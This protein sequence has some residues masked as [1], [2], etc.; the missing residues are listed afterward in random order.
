LAVALVATAVL[1][2]G[3][4]ASSWT[5]LI[6]LMTLDRQNAILLSPLA[7]LSWTAA[8]N[9]WVKGRF[10]RLILAIA[11]A[12]WAVRVCGAALKM[13][14]LITVGRT[15]FAILFVIIIVRITLWGERRIAA[16]P[17]MLIVASALF[18]PELSRVGIPTIW[19][20]FNI[21][22]TLTQYA[23]ALALVLLPFALRASREQGQHSELVHLP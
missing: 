11:T 12:A 7:M 5:D 23:Y 21:G 1:R 6:S 3:N 15:I 9:D 4:A 10:R 17:I 20:P 2:L 22:V 14:N 18:I 19:F 8:W 13:D 16:I